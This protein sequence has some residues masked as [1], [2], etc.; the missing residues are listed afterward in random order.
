MFAENTQVSISRSLNAYWQSI[1]RTLVPSPALLS[2]FLLY[3]SFTAPDHLVF[4]TIELSILVAN[5]ETAANA[6][7][8]IQ[9]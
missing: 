9:F 6:N 1:L 2:E 3:Y 5:G 4:C 7:A 8:S